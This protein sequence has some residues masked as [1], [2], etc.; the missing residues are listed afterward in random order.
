M[1]EGQIIV[2]IVGLLLEFGI[3]WFFF[4]KKE[5]LAKV[6]NPGEII[7][8]TVDGGYKPSTIILKKDKKVM[9]R[10]IRKDE[11]SCLEEVVF[12]DYGIK[13]YL[14]LNT[15]VD[16]ELKPPHATKTGF[17]CAMNMFQGRLV[18]E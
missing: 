4:G 9:L 5:I 2:I 3:Y 7:E 16:V 14:P 15:S 13:K 12:P 10:F 6:S 18:T 17:H 11:N 8:I 1:N